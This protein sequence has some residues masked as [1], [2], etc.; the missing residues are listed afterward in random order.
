MSANNYIRVRE[1]PLERYEVSERNSENDAKIEEFGVFDS[2]RE[3][4]QRAEKRMADDSWEV[5]YGIEFFSAIEK[6]TDDKN[7]DTWNIKKK[8]VNRGESRLYT[9]REIWWCSLGV[10]IGSEQDGSGGEGWLSR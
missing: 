2:L 10:N 6:E 4:M 1:L 7:F 5:E 9:E 8:H 3:A